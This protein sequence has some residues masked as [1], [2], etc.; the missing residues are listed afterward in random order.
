M[1]IQISIHRKRIK[2][3]KKIINP[4]VFSNTVTK[5][6]NFI[7]NLWF[8]KILYIVR[9]FYDYSLIKFS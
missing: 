3:M 1:E 4:A 8:L 6:K 5:T 7:G 2:I 9:M